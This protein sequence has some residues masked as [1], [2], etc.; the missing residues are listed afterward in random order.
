MIKDLLNLESNKVSKDLKDY[1]LLITAPSGYGK[2]QPLD[3]LVLTERG[4]I[5]MG[6]ITLD[7]KVY[8]ED[9]ELHKV[10]AIYPQGEKEIYRV[11]FSD[12]TYAEC[13][14]EHLWTVQTP[15]QRVDKKYETITL[16]EIMN[17]ELYKASKEGYKQWQFYIP[18]TKPVQFKEAKVNIKPYILGLLIGDGYLKQGTIEFTNTEEDIIDAIKTE[19]KISRKSENTIRVLDKDGSLRDELDKLGLRECSE[20]KYIPNEYLYN[21]IETRLE[22]LRGLVDTDGYVKNSS[23]EYSTTSERLAKDVKFLV[24]SLGGTANIILKANPIYYCQGKKKCGKDSYR[25]LIKMPKSIKAFNS[26]KHNE[27]FS[28]GQTEA[29]RTIRRIEKIGVKKAQCIYIDNPTHLYLTNNFIVTHNTPFLYELYGDRALFLSFENSSKGIAGIMSV[30]IDSYNTLN[31]YVQQLQKPEVREKFDVIVI[32]TLFLFDHFIEKSI[33]DRYGKETLSDCLK[34]N[35]AY[36][37]VDKKFLDVVKKIQSMNYSM[38]YVCHP[39]E[40]TIKLQDGTEITKI[41]PKV[42]DRIKNLL[43]PEV[44]IR[45][46]CGFDIQGNKVIYTQNSTYF[47]ARVR[48]GDM[49]AVVPFN[50]SKF[51]EEFS[52][53]IERRVDKKMLVNNI[54]KKNVVSDAPKSFTD[55]MNEIMAVGGR[56]STLGKVVEANMI[57]NQELGSNEE[58]RQ[59]TLNECNES[60]INVLEVILT[61]LLAYENS[62]Q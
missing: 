8:G 45:I 10:E 37:I 48:V 27:R 47:D 54:D 50:A 31:A 25:V 41:E 49:E 24:E 14:K 51:K 13:C 7:D 38:A 46:Y 22:I 3:S 16:E 42:S 4:Y 28:E 36:K 26:V 19:Y 29:R 59:R 53:G 6:D 1:S 52:K 2:A 5:Q 30:E 61:N 20:D 55:V 21:S 32:D 34:Y 17:K 35:K 39:I 58:G 23:I 56:L 9:G 62:L 15:S 43:I 44:D 18:M 40:K 60:H 33:V 11:T 57:I 12:G